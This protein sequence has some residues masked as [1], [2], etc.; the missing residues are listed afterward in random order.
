VPASPSGKGEA[1]IWDLSNFEFKDVG[2][3][4]MGKCSLTFGGLYWEA[5]IMTK[6]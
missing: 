2:T 4:V 5:Y 1:S 3:A 6:F